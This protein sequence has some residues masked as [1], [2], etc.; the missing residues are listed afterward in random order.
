MSTFRTASARV[1]SLS[2]EDRRT[3]ARFKK[4]FGPEDENA[5][6]TGVEHLDEL[7]ARY[8]SELDT[9]FPADQR[10]GIRKAV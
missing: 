2:T 7:R 5:F 6:L 1:Q 4:R 10:E 8:S 3:L 9:I